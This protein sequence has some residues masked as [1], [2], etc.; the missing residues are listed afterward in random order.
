M[1]EELGLEEGESDR[2]TCSLDGSRTTCQV[3]PRG[4]VCGLLRA[5]HGT[6][7]SRLPALAAG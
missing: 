4:R 2:I 7:L 3:P 1:Y 6:L 5:R